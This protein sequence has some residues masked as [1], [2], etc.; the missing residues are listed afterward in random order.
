MRDEPRPIVP[1]ES[2]RGNGAQHSHGWRELSSSLSGARSRESKLPGFAGATP[3][4][5]PAV[6][7][8]HCVRLAVDGK[9]DS[10]QGDLWTS[11]P[12]KHTEAVAI[13][14]P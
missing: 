9:S 10:R 2:A 6:D 7:C 13:A 8:D 5:L 11:D 14:A 4:E 1:A 12:C 3:E